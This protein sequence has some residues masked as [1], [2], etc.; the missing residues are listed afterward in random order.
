MYKSI[1]P[2]KCVVTCF[3]LRMIKTNAKSLL[4]V[5]KRNVL[6]VFFIAFSFCSNV[7]AQDP[8]EPTS[9][10]DI[11][12][13][14]IHDEDCYLENLGDY[15]SNDLSVVDVFLDPG[16]PCN[17]CDEN[18]EVTANLMLTLT[19]TT[20]SERGSFAIFGVLET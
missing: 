8:C 16:D 19:N 9:P 13:P 11:Y 7:F 10:F 4:F 5:K 2:K 12:N 17:A 3:F 18:D 15:V 14:V 6:L 20:G 1:L